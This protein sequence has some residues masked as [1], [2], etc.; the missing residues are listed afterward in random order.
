MEKILRI[1]KQSSP[2][3]SPFWE[4]FT[5]EAVNAS[6][7]VATAL[8]TLPVSW[9]HSCLQ[10]RC[11]ACAMVINGVP[12]LACGTRLSELKGGIVTVEPL[13][14]FP[15]IKDLIVDR[16]AMM[17][18][19][20]NLSV[21]FESEASVPDDSA[22]K[23]AFEASRCLQC[24]ICLEVCPNYYPGGTFG[25]MAAMGS[26]ARLISRLPPQ[27]KKSIRKSY[28]NGVYEGCGKSLSCQNVCPAGI[29]IENL[30][31]RCASRI[32]WR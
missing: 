26:L 6:D 13:R 20:Q 8:S 10:R 1:K 23:M 18:S 29:D 27:Q 32:I 28:K 5:Y 12:R 19:L 24:G 11:G 30:L 16:Q 3:S 15:V 22:E 2:D 9:E 21:W 7:T 14:K 25:G 4:D 17:D 31:V